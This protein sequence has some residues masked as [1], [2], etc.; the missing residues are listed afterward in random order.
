MA[1]AVTL[2]WWRRDLRIHDHQALTAALQHGAVVGLFIHT[3]EHAC[4][5][6][7]RF[8]I[9]RGAG[10]W[11]M[12]RSLEQLQHQLQTLNIPL[13]LRRGEPTTIIRELLDTLPQIVRCMWNRSYFPYQQ[14]MDSQVEALLQARGIPWQSFASSLLYNPDTVKTNQQRVYAQ[15]TPYYNKVRQLPPARSSHAPCPLNSGSAGAGDLN[16]ESLKAWGLAP[17][18]PAW[19]QQLQQQWQPG[20][21][22][23]LTA[24][25]RFARPPAHAEY[26]SARDYPALAGTSRLSPHLAWGEVSHQRAYEHMRDQHAWLRQLTWR[27]FS[28]YTLYHHPELVSEGAQASS[29]NIAFRD[30]AD[31]AEDF[32]RFSRGQTGY[33]LVDAGMRELYATGWMHNRVRMLVACFLT[34]NLL[35]HWLHGARWFHDTLLDACVANNLAGWLWVIKGMPHYRLFNPVKQSQKFD[36]EGKYIKTWIP[37]LAHVPA[38]RIH[39]PHQQILATQ[40]ARRTSPTRTAAAPTYPPPMIDYSISRQRALAVY[41]RASQLSRTT[42][43]TAS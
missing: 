20:E 17:D 3:P 27:E 34:K 39:D 30:D 43:S 42:T 24:L 26:T 19:A 14:T 18:Q 9:P 37:E 11:W 6:G 4:L 36:P 31:V 38:A 7:R 1:A 2:V 22:S 33:P 5:P 12:L 23:A 28:I 15:F 29:F 41:R 25:A 10:Y 40:Q 16:S 35:I 8:E 13:I 21:P 32:K